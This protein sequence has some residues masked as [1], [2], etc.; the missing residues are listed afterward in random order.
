LDR[1]A[2]W[3]QIG[4]SIHPFIRSVATQI[5]TKRGHPQHIA[6]PVCCTRLNAVAL[7][8]LQSAPDGG[9]ATDPGMSPFEL[10]RQSEERG[11]V[12]VAPRELHSDRQSLLTPGERQ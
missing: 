10:C 2:S 11:L 1:G 5:I 12:G 3:P 9:L 4:L 6:L 8:E 7:L